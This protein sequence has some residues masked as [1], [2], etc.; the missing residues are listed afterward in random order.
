VARD[1]EDVPVRDARIESEDVVV[2][3][4]R[5]FGDERA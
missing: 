5:E 2:E 1:N 4:G 3:V